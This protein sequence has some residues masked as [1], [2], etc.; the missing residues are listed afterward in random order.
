M[1]AGMAGS[2]THFMHMRRDVGWVDPE[3][4]P[5][6]AQRFS[7]AGFDPA[8]ADDASRHRTRGTVTIRRFPLKR[9]T[10]APVPIPYRDDP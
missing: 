8:G 5:G 2:Y 1:V 9:G 6:G 4:R 7:V 3:R 10:H